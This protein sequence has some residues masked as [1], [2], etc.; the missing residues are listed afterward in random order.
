MNKQ[1]SHSQRVDTVSL[2]TLSLSFVA[3]MAVYAAAV[4]L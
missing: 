3:F 2:I 1:K 4:N